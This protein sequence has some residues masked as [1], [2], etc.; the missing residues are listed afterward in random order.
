MVRIDLDL[1]NDAE[2]VPLCRRLVRTALREAGVHQEKAADIE[3]VV[4]EA[5]TNAVRHAEG[6]NRYRVLV[7]ISPE[8][9][10]LQVADQGDGFTR[11]QIADPDPEQPGGRGLWLMEQLADEVAYYDIADDGVCLRAEFRLQSRHSG[12]EADAGGG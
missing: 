3:L 1:P 7:E 4:S 2:S 11:E 10:T 6:G 8:C 5:T 12:H 9:L